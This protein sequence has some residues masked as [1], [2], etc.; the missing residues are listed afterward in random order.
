MK[1]IWKYELAVHDSQIIEM[2]SG[3]NIL[4]VQTQ[5]GVPCLWVEVRTKREIKEKRKIETFGTGHKMFTDDMAF[6]RKYIGTYQ[7][8]GD[9]RDSLVFHVYERIDRC[10][11][12][13][14]RK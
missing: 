11:T 10:P 12:Y 1:A 13:G 4:C 3:A 6:V 5:R 7:L 8:E 14:D 2:P 9:S